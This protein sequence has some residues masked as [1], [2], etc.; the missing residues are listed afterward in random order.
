MGKIVEITDRAQQFIQEE[1]RVFSDPVLVL[2]STDRTVCCGTRY[3]VSA[4]ISD[5][6]MIGIAENFEELMLSPLNIPILVEKNNFK[7]MGNGQD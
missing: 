1:A 6:L 3:N 2:V 5:R 7:L 4:M